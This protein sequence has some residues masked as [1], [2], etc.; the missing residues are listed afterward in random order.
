MTGWKNRPSGKIYHF[1]TT[2]IFPPS[3][4]KSRQLFYRTNNFLILQRF[5]NRAFNSVGL[6]RQPA[7]DRVEE[8][9]FREN[10]SFFY[11]FN[12]PPSKIKSRQLFYR[13]N[14]FLIL[15]RFFN[16][17]FNSVG[18]VRQPAD[19]RV[20]EQTFR[21]NLSFF[22]HF[23]FPPSKIKSRQL[24]Y[25]TNNFLILQRF[26]NRAFNSVGLECHLDR[27]E[28]T[29]SNPVMPTKLSPPDL[30]PLYPTNFFTSFISNTFSFPKPLLGNVRK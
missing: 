18:L 24:F 26:F 12:F 14:N 30:L 22:Y 15:Q 19:D 6:V 9:T 8:Q 3:K 10:L 20:E 2:L 13:T 21:E 27:V 16:R 25:R 29:G 7:D 4:I 17:A 23:N 28:V 5:F 11:H 1:F